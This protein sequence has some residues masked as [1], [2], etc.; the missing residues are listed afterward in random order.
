MSVVILAFDSDIQTRPSEGPHTS[1]LRIWHKSVR[2]FPRYFT[3]KQT[4][5][6]TDSAKNRT[7]R[8]SLLAVITTEQQIDTVSRVTETTSCL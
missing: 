5:N 7:L 8:S 3:P 2:Q 1:S 4:K 6:V